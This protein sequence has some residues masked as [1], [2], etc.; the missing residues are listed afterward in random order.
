MI[1][2]RSRAVA[3]KKCTKKRD[4]RPELLLC[5]SKP[6]AFFEVLVAVAV[7]VAVAV[8][9]AKAPYYSKNPRIRT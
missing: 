5:L 1:S 2:R 8:V 4:E 7:A 3:T 6:L 9:V